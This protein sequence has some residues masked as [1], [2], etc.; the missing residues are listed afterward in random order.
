[1]CA[2]VR[3]IH[4]FAREVQLSEDEWTYAMDLLLRAGKISDERRNEFIMFS[5]T[6]GL[7][8]VVDLLSHGDGML[9]T[10]ASQLGPFFV[11]NLAISE[12]HMVDLRR[13]NPGEPV[14]FT[15]K[16]ID[17]EGK[18]I[19]DAIV[20]EWQTDSEGLYDV[21]LKGLKEPR[22]RCRLRVGE[23]GQFVLKTVRPRGYTA[24]MDG[25]GGEMLSATKRNIW[26]PAHFHFRIQAKG[27]ATIVTELFPEG[28]EH[29][30]NDVAFGVRT[31][32]ILNLPKCTSAEVGKKVGMPVPFTNVEYTFWMRRGRN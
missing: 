31:P 19:R 24:P 22:F 7:S 25:P 3:H 1:M 27:Y 21:Q 15:G 10:P 14:L 8:A 16:V 26:R 17:G 28:D 23:N 6:L 20:D 12:S 29:L 9:E 30:D 4:G 5:D 13:E 32:L 2:L 18:P 11:D